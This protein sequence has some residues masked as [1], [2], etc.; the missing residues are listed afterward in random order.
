[1]YGDGST[2]HTPSRRGRPP[3]SATRARAATASSII[4]SIIGWLPD[5]A[6]AGRNDW[7]VQKDILI[8]NDRNNMVEP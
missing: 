1:M 8:C 5:S 4:W 2:S 7:N 6:T 3:P